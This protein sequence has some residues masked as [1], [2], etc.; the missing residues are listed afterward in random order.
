MTLR[1]KSLQAGIMAAAVVGA[2]IVSTQGTAYAKGTVTGSGRPRSASHST[3]PLTQRLQAFT[4]PGYSAEALSSIAGR[5]RTGDPH[6]YLLAIETGGS[7]P[8]LRV[9]QLTRAGR[10]ITVTDREAPGTSYDMDETTG[11][12]SRDG[13]LVPLDHIRFWQGSGSQLADQYQAIRNHFSG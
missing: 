2:V 11:A 3:H 6:G 9:L 12:I 7:E 4:Q 10:F 1:R 13:A 8:A 5:M